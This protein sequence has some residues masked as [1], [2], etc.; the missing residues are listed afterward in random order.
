[1]LWVNIYSINS[2]HYTE[3]QVI[4]HNTEYWHLVMCEPFWSCSLLQLY[5]SLSLLSPNLLFFSRV[6]IL[7]TSLLQGIWS[8]GR[9]MQ[10]CNQRS[11]PSSPSLRHRR[12]LWL[13]TLSSSFVPLSVLHD[14]LWPPEIH[15]SPSF[16][17]VPAQPSA[18]SLVSGRGC[19][20]MGV[21]PSL[22]QGPSSCGSTPCS[23]PH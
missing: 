10:S 1:M 13:M 5:F 11:V 7:Q 20:T 9:S 23:E 22:C 16:P 19:W 17:V 15:A 14:P 21:W 2:N 4:V 18:G 3:P 12:S 6:Q 8:F